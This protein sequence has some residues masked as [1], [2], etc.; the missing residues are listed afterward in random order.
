M[1]R[2]A[3]TDRIARD[4]AEAGVPDDECRTVAEATVDAARPTL[5]TGDVLGIAESLFR[6]F[7]EDRGTRDFVKPRRDGGAA[8]W[9]P[10]NVVVNWREGTWFAAGAAGQSVAP[11]LGTL[12]MI[13]ALLKLFEVPL[14]RREALLVQVLWRSR[15]QAAR[16]VEA[17]APEVTRA[18]ERA[19]LGPPSQGELSD[20]LDRLVTLRTVTRSGEHVKLV[21]R[22]APGLL[23]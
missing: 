5:T 9:K 17:L 16:P 19:G 7:T 14:G 23:T 1:D 12:V 13:R 6:S 22:F 3:L 2:D 10:S 4:L 8:S 21:E 11:V 15:S 18:F 20:M